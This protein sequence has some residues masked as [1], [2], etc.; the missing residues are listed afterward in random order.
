MDVLNE[1]EAMFES[2]LVDSYLSSPVTVSVY[3]PNPTHTT[4]TKRDS[5]RTR[6]KVI[7]HY[8]SGHLTLC[9]P[10]L[11]CS[12]Q[13]VNGGIYANCLCMYGCRKESLP[14]TWLRCFSRRTQ[15]FSLPQ[16]RSSEN[17]FP[18]VLLVYS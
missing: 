3:I 10:V 2:P 1:E 15:S 4:L 9:C 14:E 5:G 18:K 17:Y 8:I 16:H 13:A 11:F 6:R 7:I 12:L